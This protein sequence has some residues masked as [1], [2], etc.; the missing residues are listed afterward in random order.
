MNL[1]QLFISISIVQ[2]GGPS[3]D[4]LKVI[5]Y[6]LLSDED[7]QNQNQLYYNEG[8]ICA[9]GNPGEGGCDVSIQ[10]EIRWEN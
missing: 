9:L 10:M 7:C 8:Q 1:Y 4:F 5:D 3:P 2:F 6:D